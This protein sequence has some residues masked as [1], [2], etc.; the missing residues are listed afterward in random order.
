MGKTTFPFFREILMTASEAIKTPQMDVLIKPGEEE[1]AKLL[2]KSF[3]RI[4]LMEVTLLIILLH[5]S[6][7]KH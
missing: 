4:T 2:A 5:Y 1:N 6:L 3:T 7:L